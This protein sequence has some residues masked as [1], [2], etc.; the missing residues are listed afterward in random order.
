M[1]RNCHTAPASHRMVGLGFGRCVRA[2][3]QA[4]RKYRTFARLARYSDVP[5]H[6][7]RELTREGKAEARATEALRRGGV[8]LAELL[9]QL[10][11]LLSIRI[12]FSV[13]TGEPTMANALSEILLYSCVAA[14]VT[15]IVIV[16]ASLIS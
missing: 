6:H 12:R 2:D 15:G 4:H 7:T 9:E 3:R 13:H 11:L 1:E 5:T 8:G 10:G 14:F 16:A